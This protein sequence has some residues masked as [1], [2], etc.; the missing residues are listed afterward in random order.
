MKLITALIKCPISLRNY[1]Q[2]NNLR[3]MGD[4]HGQVSQ[5]YIRS[6]FL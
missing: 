5:G 1:K 4:N 6:Q 3:A 2:Y